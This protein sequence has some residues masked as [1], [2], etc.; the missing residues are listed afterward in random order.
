MD[1]LG[2]NKSKVYNIIS[3]LKVSKYIE[4]KSGTKRPEWIILKE[5]NHN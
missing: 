2:L 1:N 4:R 5:L 3:A